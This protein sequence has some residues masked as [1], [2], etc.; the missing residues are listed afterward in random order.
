[1]S[2]VMDGDRGSEASA[3]TRVWIWP[4]LLVVAGEVAMFLAAA[5]RG[6][7]LTDE[8]FYLLTFQH[9][10]EWPSV[11][12]F[13]AYFSLP[14]QLFGQSVWAIRVLG[15]I[16]LLTA[17]VWFSREVHR[18]FDALALRM[19]PDGIAA[20]S[21]AGGAS[22]WNYYGAFVV[23]Y[24]P[25]YNLLTLA[26]ALAAM[27]L[28]MRVGRSLFQHDS[29]TL[30]RDSFTLGVVASVGIASKFSAG[31]LVLGLCAL[32]IVAFGWRRVETRIAARIAVA[33]AAG[34]ALN[35]AALWLA[36]PDLPT[37]FQRGIAVTLAMYPRSPANELIGFLFTDV[38]QA[39]AL[40]L[41]I[42]MWPLLIA[43]AVLAAGW[44]VARRALFDSLA[45]AV[46]VAGATWVTYVKDNRAHRL[47]LLTLVALG[48]ALARWWLARGRP[49]NASPARSWWA[50][51]AVLAVPFAYSFGTN[52]PLLRHMG[53]AAAF[54][55]VLATM[56]VRSMWTE[57]SISRW[58]F[59]LSLVLL[60]TFPAEIVVRQWTSGQYTYRLGAALGE[61]TARMPANAGR[62]DVTVHPSLARTVGDFLALTRESGFVAG[63]PM[64][65]FTGQSPGL[66]ALAG[67][68]PVGAIWFVGG[69]LFDGDGMARLSLSYVDAKDV[70]RAW[71]LTSDDSFARIATWQ[72]IIE[73]HLGGVAHEQAGHVV[74]ADPTSDDKTKTIDVILWRPKTGTP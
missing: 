10:T 72:S 9:W 36:D 69:P 17:C 54:P 6:L 15:F 66:V 32:V 14:Y 50:A 67:G 23:P 68:V 27:A 52:N 71:L 39:V 24:T 45:V 33:L 2:A 40:S 35:V 7:D 19:M 37:R 8:G 26:C 18:A 16:L 21:V 53:M 61:Q 3:S 29:A 34:A 46:F 4:V 56:L 22:V 48:L 60:A 13:G 42:L 31:V 73:T 63:Q 25:S 20:A 41:R 47:V 49:T 65:D 74:V 51:A 1:M 12:L 30:Y 11:S 44:W 64:I 5:G 38:P 55:A 59:A 43:F 62:I 58:A 57:R 28:A 70:R